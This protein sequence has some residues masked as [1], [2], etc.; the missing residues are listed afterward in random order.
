MHNQPVNVVRRAVREG[1]KV[2][3]EDETPRL[4]CPP[5]QDASLQLRD[6][7]RAVARLSQP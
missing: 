7:S 1:I 6:L 5:I 3:I 4:A 2:P